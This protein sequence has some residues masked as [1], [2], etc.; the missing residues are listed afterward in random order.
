MLTLQPP[1]PQRRARPRLGLALAGG[2]P[3]GACYE[4]G[5]LQARA[6]SSEG[7]DHTR[8]DAYVG[9]SSGAMVAAGLANGIS[10]ADMGVVFIDNAAAAYPPSPGPFLQPALHE[11][12]ARAR[13]APGVDR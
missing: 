10:T 9:V 1:R 7:L 12:L 11:F 13:A 2:G 3:L 4:I 6:E 8:L 5:A